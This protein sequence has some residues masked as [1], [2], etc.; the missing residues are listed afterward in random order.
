MKVSVDH[1]RCQGHA[2]CITFAPA[3]FAID[4]EG[5]ASVREG[6]EQVSSQLQ[7]SVRSACSNCPERAI[8]I[9][10]D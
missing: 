1:D 8:L 10:D 9:S 3:V 5:Y 7:E 2:R 4:G 6:C